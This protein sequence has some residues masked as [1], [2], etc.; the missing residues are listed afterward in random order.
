MPVNV[1]MPKLGLT[2]EKGTIVR[3][4]KKEG[5]LLIQ[6]EPLVEILT[7]KVTYQV[8]APASGELEKI[9]FPENTEIPVTQPIAIIK[10]R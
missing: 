7:D 3:W 5:D 2:M 1:V 6:G 10:E 9:L 4:L 8:D